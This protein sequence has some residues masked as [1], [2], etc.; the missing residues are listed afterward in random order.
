VLQRQA[1]FHP[2]DSNPKA[3]AV[4]NA[5]HATLAGLPQ[6]PGAVI[7]PGSLDL[8]SDDSRSTTTPSSIHRIPSDQSPPGGGYA[9]PSC[10]NPT[11]GFAQRA[12]GRAGLVPPFTCPWMAAL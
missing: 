3:E 10:T 5:V 12:A 2:I 8:K 4:A 11:Q 6:G 1:V 9:D 7:G